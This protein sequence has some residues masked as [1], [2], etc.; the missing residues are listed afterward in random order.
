MNELDDTQ[1]NS[2]PLRAAGWIGP[3][4][5]LLAVRLAFLARPASHRNVLAGD[6]LRI[7]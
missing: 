4:G 2:G 6:E 5:A 7:L 1:T 3:L